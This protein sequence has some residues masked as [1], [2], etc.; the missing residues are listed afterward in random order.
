MRIAYITIT[1]AVAVILVAMSLNY[2]VQAQ[3]PT[4]LVFTVDFTGAVSENDTTAA[5]Y[6]IDIE[7][8]RLAGL[9]PPV[10]PLLNSTGAEIKASY[11]GLLS[12]LVT[13]THDSYIQ[14]AIDKS[15]ETANAEQLW[16]DATD[17]QRAAAI[18]ALG[19]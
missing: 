2:R 6:I 15:S 12:T 16:K 1:V 18:T 7:N 19:G 8:T 3:Q 5:K 10:A 13:R 4:L 11:L 14:Q 9:D 17:S